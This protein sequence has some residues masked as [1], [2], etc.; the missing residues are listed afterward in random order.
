MPTRVHRATTS[1]AR[2]S[3]RCPRALLSV[4]LDAIDALRC[5]PMHAT[6][7]SSSTTCRRW[8][9]RRAPTSTNPTRLSRIRSGHPLYN[10]RSTRRPVRR[11][12]R[13][14]PGH[15]R[16]GRPGADLLRRATATPTTWCSPSQGRLY[17]SDNGPNGGWGGVPL[18][19]DS[20][21]T[22]SP[23]A[24]AR[25]DP[26]AGDY[27]TNEFN[28][29]DSNG[30]GDTLHFIDGPGYYGGHPTPI[31]AIPGL[32]R[33]HRLRRAR[34][35]GT[36]RRSTTSSTCCRPDIYAGRSSRDNPVECDYQRQRLQTSISTSSARRP[37]ASPSTPPRTSAARCRATS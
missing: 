24:P 12:Q 25:Y 21:G 7:T 30:H 17:T 37:T 33:C 35:A 16:T 29:T 10:S 19:Y 32:S 22:P 27:C 6:A 9:T 11:Q 15:P 18:I 8:T 36:K 1:P 3:T 23:R 26:G 34:Q 2:P 4:D 14:E 5:R 28:E 20:T 31:R 13:P